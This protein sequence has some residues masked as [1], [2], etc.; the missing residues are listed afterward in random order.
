MQTPNTSSPSRD[1]HEHA[2]ELGTGRFHL[3]FH[4]F[5]LFSSKTDSQ[6]VPIQSLSSLDENAGPF[7]ISFF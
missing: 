2:N 7:F 4:L 5:H 6:P 3:A 1:P